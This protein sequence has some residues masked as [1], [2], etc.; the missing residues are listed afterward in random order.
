MYHLASKKLFPSKACWK[1]MRTMAMLKN[2]AHKMSRNLTYYSLSMDLCLSSS[3]ALDKRGSAI[4]PFMM[5]MI[6]E[7]PYVEAF[8]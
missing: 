5:T 4:N 6:K 2:H 7:G 3:E 8:W 1:K